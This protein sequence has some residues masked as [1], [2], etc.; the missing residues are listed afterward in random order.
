MVRSKTNGAKRS[1][2]NKK[3]QTSLLLAPDHEYTINLN[4]NYIVRE[5]EAAKANNNGKIPY[6]GISNICE[7]MK[8]ALPWL[9]KDMI[10]YHLKK[11]NKC[12]NE[13][14]NMPPQYADNNNIEEESSR[15]LPSSWSS[16]STLTF[17]SICGDTH[18]MDNMTTTRTRTVDHHD[19]QGQ[20]QCCLLRAPPSL[21]RRQ[22][23]IAPPVQ[24]SPSAKYAAKNTNNKDVREGPYETDDSNVEMTPT[25]T[26]IEGQPVAGLVGTPPDEELLL[27]DDTRT[28]SCV[29]TISAS[30]FGRPKGTSVFN[31]KDLEERLQLATADAAQQYSIAREEARANNTRAARGALKKIIRISMKKYRLSHS[32]ANMKINAETVRTRA[33]RGV[34]GPITVAQGTPSPMLSIEPYVVELITQLSRMRSPINVTTGLQLANSLIACTPFMDGVL[35]WK[36]KHNVHARHQQLDDFTAAGRLGKGYWRGFMKRNGH[37]IK[38]KKAVKF[39]SKRADWCTYQN[40]KVMYDEV[41][42][43]LVKGGIATKLAETEGAILF[44]KKGDIVEKTE[45]AFG[46]STRYI[47]NRPDKLIFVDEVG[48]NTNTSKDG[49]I[50]GEKFLCEVNTRPQIRVT[51]K[52]SHFTVLGFTTALG[53]PVMCSIIFAAKELHESWVLGFDATADWI[54]DEQNIDANT[55]GIGKQYPMGPTCTFNNKTIPTFCCCSENGSITAELLVEML[56]ALDSLD[57][58]D[59]SDGIPPFLLLDGH[60]SRFDYHFLKYISEPETK[61]NVCIGVPYGTSYWQVGDSNEQNGCFK[62]ALTRHKRNLLNK[63]EERREE[64]TIEKSDIVYLVALAWA[65]SFARVD[66]NRNAIADRGWSPLNYNCLAVPSRDTFNTIQKQQ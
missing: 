24:L 44:N 48:S 59:R 35:Q 25:S 39:D 19:E 57:V 21:I 38:C 9:T 31:S 22:D 43:E 63:K 8:P 66:S 6:G 11:L 62:M 10:K 64:F 7:K 29:P 1:Y 14:T 52:D 32:S 27:D 20:Q 15:T 51:T 13:A 53:V 17:G 65:D 47:M 41:Y 55:G 46:L 42:K 2:R 18:S 37:K 3:N 26:N 36:V 28:T 5:L 16:I 50:G 45:D 4:L 49:N 40:F 58:F 61:W 23:K 33:K 12:T 30:S 60:G 34:L 56:K 54:G